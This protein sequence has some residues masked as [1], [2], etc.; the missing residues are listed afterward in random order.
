VLCSSSL[1]APLQIEY[2]V[3]A[4]MS[5]LDTRPS[6]TLALHTTQAQQCGYLTAD[7]YL[8]RTLD[9]LKHFPLAFHLCISESNEINHFFCNLCVLYLLS[10]S[11]TQYS[12]FMIYLCWAPL[13]VSLSV[14]V[15]P[16]NL[17][18]KCTFLSGG[19]NIYVCTLCLI[20]FANFQI[21]LI[22]IYYIKFLFSFIFL[23]W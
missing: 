12:I 18:W 17:S 2:I 8:V 21:T 7:I 5:L 9:A 20:A 11:D 14:T 4:A 3:L 13:Q 15:T 10:C 1:P 23:Y 19:S 6:A 22:F 16:F